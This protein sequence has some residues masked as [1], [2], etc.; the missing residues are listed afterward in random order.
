MREST[1]TL[2][3]LLGSGLVLALARLSFRTHLFQ[4]EGTGALS[5]LVGCIAAA[6]SMFGVLAVRSLAADAKQEDVVDEGLASLA[7][8]VWLITLL[9][10][11]P[12]N[13]V[14]TAATDDFIYAYAPAA[15]LGAVVMRVLMWRAAQRPAHHP[16]ASL[17]RH[18]VVLAGLLPLI[19]VLVLEVAQGP[20]AASLATRSA[21]LGAACA[22]VAL[23]LFTALKLRRR[24]A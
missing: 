4:T 13:F 7:L 16:W 2:G 17:V 5:D 1:K 9:P 20:G 8:G 14:A 11:R 19:G 3:W 10:P 22:V 24:E 18:F 21:V 15:M 12:S 23:A 6:G